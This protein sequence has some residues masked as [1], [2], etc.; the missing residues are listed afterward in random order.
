MRDKFPGLWILISTLRSD[1]HLP[2]CQFADYYI[3][4]CGLLV[5]YWRPART[6]Q[7][8]RDLLSGETVSVG[9]TA[10]SLLQCCG[11]ST[12]TGNTSHAITSITILLLLLLLLLLLTTDCQEVLNV[13]Y[14]LETPDTQS[15]GDTRGCLTHT[16]APGKIRIPLNFLSLSDAKLDSLTSSV[17]HL[18]RPS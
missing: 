4:E 13:K 6:S 15:P 18:P 8:H 14:H 11:S 16:Y 17:P 12:S 2:L 1:W 10:Q 7:T 3:S 5:G 9:L